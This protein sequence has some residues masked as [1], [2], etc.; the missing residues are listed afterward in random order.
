[1]QPIGAL[2]TKVNL[3]DGAYGYD[4]SY[5]YYRSTHEVADVRE[6]PSA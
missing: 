6:L 1:M 5:Y 2:M 4:S 3:R